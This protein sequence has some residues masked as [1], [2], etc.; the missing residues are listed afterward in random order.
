MIASPYRIEPPALVS[1]SGGRTSAFMLHE[2]LAAHGGLLPEGVFVTFANTGKEREETLRFV[3]EC[4]SRWGVRIHW[5][6]YRDGDKS[7]ASMRVAEVGYNSASR[8]GEPFEFLIRRKRALPNWQARFCTQHLKVLTMF[9]FMQARGFAPGEY[10]E[11]VGLRA[12]EQWRVAKM[13]G[14][15]SDEGR[16]CVAPLFTAGVTKRAVMEFWRA[17][18]FDLALEPG[19][20]NCDL[21]FMKGAKLRAQLIRARPESARWW[22]DQESAVGVT[23]E[24]RTTYAALARD[25]ERQPD[26]F[27]GDSDPDD[28]HDAECGLW[29]GSE[30]A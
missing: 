29:C 8:D 24:K 22:M 27:I 6:E 20:G 21:C 1:F 19:E 25:V 26:L 11:A 12:D 7:L 13:H 28:E 5:L 18:P 15:N 4:G 14:R 23:F 30:A 3:H 10:V 16:R 2:I 9:A 17:Q